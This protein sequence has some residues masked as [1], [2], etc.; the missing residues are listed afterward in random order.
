[1][2]NLIASSAQLVGVAAVIAGAFL[3]AVPAGVATA[4]AFVLT[5]GVLMDRR[6]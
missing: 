4:G 3:W 5:V 2:R 6:L 1:M